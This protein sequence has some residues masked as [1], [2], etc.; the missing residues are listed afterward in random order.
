MKDVLIRAVKTFI[1]SFL[2][3]VIPEII[4]ILNNPDQWR[5]WKTIILPFIMSGIASGI[6]A[7]WN[8]AINKIEK[9]RLSI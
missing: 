1:Q 5:D 9:D 3:I 8:F 6:S 7:I 2:G 4:I